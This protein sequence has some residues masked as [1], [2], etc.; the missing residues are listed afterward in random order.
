MKPITENKIETFAIEVLQTM[1]WEYM[2]G[3]AMCRTRDTLLPKLM[4]GEVSVKL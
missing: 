4:S 1:G 3:L 2:H